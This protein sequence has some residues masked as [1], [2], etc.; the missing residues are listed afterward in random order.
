MKQT[1]LNIAAL[2]FSSLLFSQEF[3]IERD[4]LDISS[5]ERFDSL[6]AVSD[7]NLYEDE[8]FRAR[9]TCAGEFGGSI[10]F[11]NKKTGSTTGCR[12]LCPICVDKNQNNYIVTATLLHGSGSITILEIA[13]PNKLQPF[14]VPEPRFDTIEGTD[15]IYEFN[16]VGD[17]ESNSM[18]GAKTIVDTSGLHA[19][20]SFMI[21]NNLYQVVRSPDMNEL[22]RMFETEPPG[23][24]TYF[25]EN[26]L[27]TRL[28][29]HRLVVVDTIIELFKFDTPA[30]YESKTLRLN[31]QHQVLRLV[32]ENRVYYIEIKNNN[33][34]IKRKQ[35]TT[36]PKPH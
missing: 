11:R 2:L 14:I 30:F 34:F 1:Y 31:S 8:T 20:A 21:E 36:P 5:K 16:Y 3:K 18:I 9:M 15:S 12:A 13:D 33:I 17:F 19:L 22:G 6:F 24:L 35:P 27:L 4:L 7:T 28:D 32:E 26:I 10:W 25:P 23:E 29:K